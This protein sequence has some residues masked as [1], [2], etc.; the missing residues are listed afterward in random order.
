MSQDSDFV[1]ILI[2]IMIAANLVR[3]ISYARYHSA[4]SR[5]VTK[6]NKPPHFHSIILVEY[7]VEHII[8]SG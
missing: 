4:S 3:M 2:T 1:A 6:Q 5:Q 7:A 8:A